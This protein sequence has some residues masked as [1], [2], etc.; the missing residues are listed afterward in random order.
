M[1]SEEKN[2]ELEKFLAETAGGSAVALEANRRVLS[3][4]R[5]AGEVSPAVKNRVLAGLAA[6]R[7][8]AFSWRT[9]APLAA[10]C[11]AVCLLAF[12]LTSPRTAAPE[13]SPDWRA[14]DNFPY[15]ADEARMSL[16]SEDADWRSEYDF[17]GWEEGLL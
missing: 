12:F 14:C 15:Y 16:L 8:G 3:L 11:A 13:L 9:D 17:P 5:E 1:K 4:F 10:A 7:R 6:P 2:G